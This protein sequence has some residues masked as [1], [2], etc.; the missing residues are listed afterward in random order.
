MKFP[1]SIALGVFALVFGVCVLAW[2]MWTY[3]APTPVD[4]AALTAVSAVDPTTLAMYANG[5]LGISFAYPAT[6]SITPITLPVAKSADA[7]WVTAAELTEGPAR[8]V[9]RALTPEPGMPCPAWAPADRPVGAVDLG[10]RTW[11]TRTR[12]VL[13][14]EH[15]KRVVEYRISA[16]GRCYSVVE[17]SPVGAPQGVAVPVILSQFHVASSGMLE[18]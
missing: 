8:I 17:E 13:G 16:D 5:E 18:Q 11:D 9:V 15:E 1:N 2:R 12:D 7:A 4:P 3:E 10:G 6:A 14:T